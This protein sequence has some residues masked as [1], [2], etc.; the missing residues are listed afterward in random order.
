MKNRLQQRQY[1]SYFYNFL[2]FFFPLPILGYKEF[3]FSIDDKDMDVDPSDNDTAAA[4]KGD[5]LPNNS[6]TTQKSTSSNDV[7]RELSESNNGK[8]NVSGSGNGS[9]STNTSNA[10]KS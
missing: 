9:T 6:P 10:G 7:K 2:L 5:S 3:P 4:S 1:S 8:S